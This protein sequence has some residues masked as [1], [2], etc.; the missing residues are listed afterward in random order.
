MKLVKILLTAM[1][2]VFTVTGLHAESHYNTG[3]HMRGVTIDRDQS[4]QTLA[5]KIYPRE[6]HLKTN[7][8]LELTPVLTS[9]TSNDSIVLPSFTIAGKN[10]YYSALRNKKVETLLRSGKDD[11]YQYT[12][13]VDWKDWMEFSEIKLID[14]STG[15]CGVPSMPPIEVPVANLDFRI[16]E[17]E[18][19]FVYQTPKAEGSKM[20]R[21]EGKAY[22]NFPVNRTEI[23]PDYMV[24]PVELRKI[25]SSIDSVRFNPDATV[26][27]ITLTGFAS[28]EGPYANNVRLAAGRTEALKE[29]VRAQY[30]FPKDVFH[31]NSVPEDWE[32]LRDSVAVSTLPDRLQILDFIDNGNVPIERR[33]DE[34][35][36]RFPQSYAFLLK[37][38]YP[39]LR[40]TNY[41]IDYQIR[42]FSDIDEIKEVIKTRPQNLSL[43]E[44]F[45]A[46]NSYPAGSPEAL[47]VYELASKLFPDSSV[48]NL[49]VAIAAMNEGNYQRA[50]MILARVDDSPEAIYARALVDA[51]DGDYDAALSGMEK[52]RDAGIATAA[53]AIEQINNIRNRKGDII[54]DES[55]KVE[56]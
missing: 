6:F 33:N 7:Q 50:R 4:Q 8:R 34:L 16:I 45:L 39:S 9:L 24:N 26:K 44:L 38:V 15:C 5:M 19:E 53:E 46:A 54:F 28:P 52:A 32:G 40:H 1:I 11:A 47:Y 25:L 35:R 48:A 42:T 13:M 21:I 51:L 27:S 12:A 55:F 37:N 30:T 3:Y 36:K 31:T 29:Y 14:R 10:A 17:F 20:R 41:A 18:P 43:N 56:D 23:Y 22:I 49:N 2:A